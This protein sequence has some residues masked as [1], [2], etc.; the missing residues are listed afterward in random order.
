MSFSD[1][2][3]LQYGAASASLTT[4]V[5]ASFARLSEGRYICTDTGLSTA[6]QPITLAID[7]RMNYSTKSQITTRLQ[8]AK[9]VAAIN[10]I[11]QLDD[12]MDLSVMLK[13]P[14]RS[15]TEAD[16][17]KAATAL[18]NFW[19]LPATTARLVRGER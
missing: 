11:P 10:G 14:H 2:S 12:I 8:V 4:P 7:N 1:P 6:D 5:S 16:V 9:N 3:G 13:I 17:F 18:F 19:Y 15:F